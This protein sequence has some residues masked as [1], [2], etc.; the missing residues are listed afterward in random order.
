MLLATCA[1]W[2]TVLICGS[3]SANDDPQTRNL[4]DWPKRGEM[5]TFSANSAKNKSVRL[6]GINSICC[7]LTNR[8]EVLDTLRSDESWPSFW[9]YHPLL[10]R[11]IQV[12][13]YDFVEKNTSSKC[14]TKKVPRANGELVNGWIGVSYTFSWLLIGRY[15]WLSGCK[16]LT[17]IL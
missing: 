6:D 15:D 5:Q 14:P 9:K 3:I 11:Q 13:L 1:L 2:G 10:Y 17:S 7:S 12:R 8:F 16:V 4:F